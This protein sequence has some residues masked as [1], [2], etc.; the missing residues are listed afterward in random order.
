MFKVR[1][2]GESVAAPPQMTTAQERIV[3]DDVKGYG[4]EGQQLITDEYQAGLKDAKAESKKRREKNFMLF[5]SIPVVFVNKWMREGFSVFDKNVT[6][7]D[8]E[9]KLHAEGLDAFLATNKRV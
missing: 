7:K 1:K 6:F 5:A 8:I 2:D 9:K 3:Y 4:F